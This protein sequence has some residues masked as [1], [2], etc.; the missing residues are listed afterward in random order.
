[1]VKNKKVICVIPARLESTRFPRKVLATLGGKPI[2]QWVFESAKLVNV[3]DEIIFA[4]DAKETADVVKSFGGNVCLTSKNCKTG[5]DRLVEVSNKKDSSIW[6]N[7]Q[8]DEPFISPDM[9]TTLLSS[10][11][12]DE[13]DVWTLKKKISDAESIL[14]PNTVK[15]VCDA[16]DYALYFS[17][18]PIPFYR[19]NDGIGASYFK[20]IGLF[21]YSSEALRKIETLKS[22]FLE[23]AEKLEQLRFLQHQL[24][25][26][27]H[28][29]DQ[30][31]V[32]IDTPQ[33]LEKAEK[34]VKSRINNF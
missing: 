1:M 29:T 3:F 22:S 23:D 25:I 16:H 26:R 32:G 17:R 15:V 10:C 11:G 6:V 28:E 4:V 13:A 33:D 24:K 19:D 27:V 9:I 18:S 34:L 5:T 12:A 2:L 31:V 14:C 30:E 21:A 20:H 7:W 8:A